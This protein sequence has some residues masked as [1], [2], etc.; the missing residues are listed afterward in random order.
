[1]VFEIL[2]KTTP[3]IRNN[4][5]Q[6][7]LFKRITSHNKIPF[8]SMEKHGFDISQDA[9]NLITGLLAKS[10]IDRM[11]SQAGGDGSIRNDPWFKGIFKD[12]LLYNRQITPPFVPT[13]TDLL[14]TSCFD[15]FLHVELAEKERFEKESYRVDDLFIGF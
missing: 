1:M 3:F 2:T 12:K 10:P 11:G 6:K 9:K 14:D 4:I 7:Q 13:I 5:T 15:D 8:P